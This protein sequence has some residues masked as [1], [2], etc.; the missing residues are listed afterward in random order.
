MASK[1][2]IN[3]NG[4]RLFFLGSKITVDG[5]CSIKLKYTCFLEVKL[6]PNKIGYLKTETLLCQQKSSPSYNFSSSYA[7]MREMDY[8]ESWALKNWCFWS[9]L[10]E[11][12]LESPLDSKGIKLVSKKFSPEY[13]LE[14]LMQKLKLQYFGYL[15]QR[16]DSFKWPRRWERLKAEGEQNERGWDWVHH[17]LNGDEFEQ[18]MEVGDGQR[19][20]VCHSPWCYK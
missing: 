3:G 15:M 1:W 16:T 18:A 8:T 9:V 4:E 10:L 2:G 12:T 5:G 11:K 7:W 20:L 14:G 17:R 13:L 6:W 19:I